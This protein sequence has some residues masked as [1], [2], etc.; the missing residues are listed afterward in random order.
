MQFDTQGAG[1][2]NERIHRDVFL[3]SLDA[4]DE[5]GGKFRLFREFF[6]AQRHPL[7]MRANGL[8]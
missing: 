7:A 1:D 4:I 8:A 6:L 3:A 5:D 2:P